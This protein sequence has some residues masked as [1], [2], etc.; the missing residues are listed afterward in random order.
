M[1]GRRKTSFFCSQCGNES[2]VWNGRC[3]ACGAWNTMV[4]EPAHEAQGLK[5]TSRR[6]VEPL[7]VGS[8]PEETGGRIPTGIPELDRVLGGGLFKGSM[9]LLGGEPGI[10]KSTLMLQLSHF[11][12]LAGET[13][14][15]ATAE[16]SPGQIASRARRIGCSEGEVLVLPVTQL[17]EI[18]TALGTTGAG[19]LIVDS[20]QTIYSEAL[21]SGPGSVA[22]VRHCTSELLR[23]TKPFGK[24]SLI[25]G[26]VTKDGTLAGPKVLEH[27]VDT[28]ISFEG[29]SNRPHRLLRALKNRFGP[30]SELGVFEMTP[31]GLAGIADA[32]A[33]FLG[34]RLDGLPG[35]VV[36]TVMEG[37]R[38]FLVEVQALTSPTRYGFPQR[39]VNGFDSRRLPMLLAVL[40]KRCGLELGAQ[41]VYVN[42]AG[43]A[44]LS[45]PGADLAICLAVASSRLERPVPTGLAVSAEVGL[46]G[47]LRPVS[48]FDRRLREARTLGFNLFAGCIDDCGEATG[49]L[50]GH[51]TL[52][53]CMEDILTPPG[54]REGGTG[55]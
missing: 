29:D 38:P 35:S 18:E 15:Y 25:V 37:T 2:P 1:K 13:V 47:E 5:S 22:Q 20:I 40:E 53:G 39:S 41:D 54:R 11:L 27:L 4:E 51:S 30:T 46:G 23:M 55:L 43:G 19:I 21:S 24:T 28:V 8:I 50:R 14:L 10:G 44:T 34:R 45:D 12:S 26:H 48:S 49:A 42:V 33:F 16:E 6:P 36:C 7:R 17:E 9:A 32:S 31:H 3:P 52:C